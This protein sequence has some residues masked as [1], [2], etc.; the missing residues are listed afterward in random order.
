MKKKHLL[1]NLVVIFLCC[2]G[3]NSSD[4]TQELSGNYFFISEGNS[5]KYIENHSS[6]GKH[7][8]SNIFSYSYDQNYILAAQTPVYASFK[9]FLAFEIRSTNKIYEKNTKEDIKISE[10][11]ADSILKN[12]TYYRNIF[13]RKINYWIICIKNDSLIGPL[14]KNDYLQKCKV[15]GIS[16]ELNLE[17]KY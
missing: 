9:S 7:I 12:N 15:L 13:S 5:E 3:C 10:V 6:M 14:S 11:L 17:S 1:F 2:Y 4:Y 16:K 8:W